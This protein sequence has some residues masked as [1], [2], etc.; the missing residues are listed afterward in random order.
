MQIA[1]KDNDATAPLSNV[2]ARIVAHAPGA[3]NAG[4]LLHLGPKVS[5]KSHKKHFFPCNVR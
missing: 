4:E 3:A 5:A 1:L 2:S